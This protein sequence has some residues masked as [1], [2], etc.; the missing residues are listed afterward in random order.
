MTTGKTIALTVRTF[1]S[2]VMFLLFNVLS[3]FVIDFL[4]RSKCL[5]FMVSITV[6]SDFWAQ[7]S[8]IC[9]CFHFISFYFP[10]SDGTRCHDQSI[11]ECW[12]LCQLTHPFHLHQEAIFCSSSL[13]AI[14]VVSS[15]FRLPQWLNGK[16]SICNAGDA[17]LIPGLGRSLGEGHGNPLQYSC[18][19]NSMDIQSE[20]AEVTEYI[21]LHSDL[22]RPIFLLVKNVSSSLE[23]LCYSDPHSTF[24]SSPVHWLLRK[25]LDCCLG[26][27][28][29][30][31]LNIYQDFIS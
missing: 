29:S 30:S 28:E 26:H 23:T 19:G 22:G 16:E 21:H 18:L 8:K 11:F 4:L 31:A 5:N 3:R 2:K 15:A 10:W 12:V 20:M 24:W 27:R 7:E 9:H 1:V 17:G 13:Y 14:T 6:R 25:F